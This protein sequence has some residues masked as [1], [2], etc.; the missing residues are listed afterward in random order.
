MNT[1]TR[2]VV[3]AQEQDSRTVNIRNRDDPKTQSKG[4]L[5]PLDQAIRALRAL[6]DC[7]QLENTLRLSHTDDDRKLETE[8]EAKQADEIRRLKKEVEQLKR[9]T[10]Q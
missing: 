6:K 3:G 10:G 1:L 7:R 2:Q 5:V 9:E 4:A 8:I